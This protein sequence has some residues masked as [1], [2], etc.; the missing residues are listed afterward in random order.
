MVHKYDCLPC[1]NLICLRILFLFLIEHHMHTL[2]QQRDPT[3][4]IEHKQRAT[5]NQIL[6]ALD[7]ISPQRSYIQA[8]I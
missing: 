4:R 5:I 8:I 6:P 7:N 3:A 1:G 2:D